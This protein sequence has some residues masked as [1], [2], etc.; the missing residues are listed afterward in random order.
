MLTAD[1][2]DLNPGRSIRIGWL[3]DPELPKFC[4]PT[5]VF[6]DS[7]VPPVVVLGGNGVEMSVRTCRTGVKGLRQGVAVDG[8][9]IWNFG[10]SK[11]V[12]NLLTGCC[13]CKCAF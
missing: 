5:G 9:R 8:V 11:E 3:E 6:G 13:D 4:W 7:A 10:G 1:K 2:V 12:F